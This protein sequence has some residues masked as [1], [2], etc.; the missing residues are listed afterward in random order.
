MDRVLGAI[1]I[2]SA[3]LMS[4]TISLAVD[5][6]LRL[7]DSGVNLQ[8]PRN[9]LLAN[10]ELVAREQAVSDLGGGYLGTSAG[11]ALVAS[12]DF[13]TQAAAALA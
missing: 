3:A 4:G 5:V 10:S 7:R 8:P 1:R 11:D 13:C 2:G 6:A 12:I 9:M